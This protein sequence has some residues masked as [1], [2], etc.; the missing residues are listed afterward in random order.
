ML[1]ENIICQWHSFLSIEHNTAKL[2]CHLDSLRIVSILNMYNN[3][4]ESYRTGDNVLLACFNNNK[5]FKIKSIYLKWIQNKVLYIK[6]SLASLVV[7]T[8]GS[9]AFDGC[10]LKSFDY[11][12]KMPLAERKIM[13]VVC[14]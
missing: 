11:H 7:S 1:R 3:E 2:I 8:L 14:Y 13:E 9:R 5:S 6:V 4:N 10:P 12:V